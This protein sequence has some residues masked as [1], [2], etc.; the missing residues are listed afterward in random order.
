MRKRFFLWLQSRDE[1]FYIK[2]CPKK[3]KNPKCKFNLQQTLTEQFIPKL[4]AHCR[5]N[6]LIIGENVNRCHIKVSQILDRGV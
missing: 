5:K 1:K 6:E 4:H 3:L 2:I